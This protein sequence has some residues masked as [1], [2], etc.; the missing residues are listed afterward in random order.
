MAGIFRYLFFISCAT[1]IGGC[2]TFKGISID[3]NIKSFFVRNFENIAPNAPPTLAVDFTERL[4]DKVRTETPLQLKSDSPDA[5]FSGR[6]IDFRVVPVAP[7]PGETVALNRLE[8]HFQVSY[9]VNLDKVEGGWASEKTFSHFAEFANDKD[10]LT[11]QDE[12]IRQISDQL[13]EDIFNAAF[14]NW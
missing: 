8:I 3:P 13:L 2:Y 12:L 10:L 7:K 11:V 9:V 5:E 14:N 4:K 1:L 6:V